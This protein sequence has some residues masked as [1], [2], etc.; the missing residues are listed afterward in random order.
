LIFLCGLSPFRK[1]KFVSMRQ[2]FHYL[3]FTCTSSQSC[4]LTF[5]RCPLSQGLL[6][7]VQ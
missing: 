2:D 4:Y 5:S 3:P 1:Q 6:G 7:S